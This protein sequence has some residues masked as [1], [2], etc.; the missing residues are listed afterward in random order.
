MVEV[1][2]AAIGS[3]DHYAQLRLLEDERRIFM[4]GCDELFQLY[5]TGNPYMVASAGVT[6]GSSSCSRINTH[7]YEEPV[8]AVDVSGI[9]LQSFEG[10]VYYI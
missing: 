1:I 8:K 10:C 9:C 6:S 5:L 4:G 7:C 3:C 2:T